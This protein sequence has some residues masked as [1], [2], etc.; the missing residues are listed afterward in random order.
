MK[1]FK[2]MN[3]FKFWSR[4][5]RKRKNS[6][7]S[8]PYHC[9]CCYSCSSVQPSAPP[10]PSWLLLELTQDAA[11]PIPVPDHQAEPFPE[12]SY[13]T[14]QPHYPSQDMVSGPMFPASVPAP[15][16]ALAASY[17]QYMVPDPVYGLPVV[18]T[19]RRERS[20]G[21]FGCVIDLGFHLI[22]CFCPCFHINE[23]VGR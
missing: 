14:D 4:K 1:M 17:Q 8:P 7:R 15:A 18:Q 3:K 23:E 22:R 10:L 11:A 13:T 16:L 2:A 21:F 5:T 9:H 19:A 6:S 12:L 20:A